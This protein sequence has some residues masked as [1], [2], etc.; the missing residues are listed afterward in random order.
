MFD[1]FK[2]RNVVKVT[3]LPRSEYVDPCDMIFWACFQIFEDFVEEEQPWE[4][5]PVDGK[6]VYTHVYDTYY[7]ELEGMCSSD[8]SRDEEAGQRA[9]AW[10]QV[11]TLY[12]WWINKRR[13]SPLRQSGYTVTVHDQKQLEKLIE[14]REV[15]WT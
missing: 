9:N 14:L 6:T 8:E 13:P 4:L 12:E 11:A 7:E 1:F 15:L 2:R 3:T 5:S 10:H